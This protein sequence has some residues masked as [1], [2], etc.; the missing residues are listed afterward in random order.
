MGRLPKPLSNEELENI[1]RKA[2]GQD[3]N[4][5]GAKQTAEQIAYETGIKG[6]L[7]LVQRVEEAERKLEVL[8]K[9][10]EKL[11][12]ESALLLAAG[13]PQPGTLVGTSTGRVAG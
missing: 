12:S 11:K 3:A 2:Q 7:P 13:K 10:V 8:E 9:E 5:V 4:V 1:R 6:L